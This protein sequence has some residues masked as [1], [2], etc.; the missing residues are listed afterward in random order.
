MLTGVYYPE[1]DK[2]NLPVIVLEKME[3]SLTSLMKKHKHFLWEKKLSILNDVCYG[4]QYLHGRNPPIIHRDLTPNNILLCDHHRAKISDLGVAKAMYATDAKT[5]TQNPGTNVFMP[6]ESLS[7]KPVYG[8]SLDIF[9]FGGVILFTCTQKWPELSGFIE[10]DCNTG[11]RK[12]LTEIQRRQ[13]YLDEMIGAFKDLK[14]LALSCLDDN[15]K[16]RPLVAKVL[17]EVK[18]VKD[19]YNEK[20]Y[21]TVLATGEHST[22]QLQH[23]ELEQQ[24]VL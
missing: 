14:S 22:T 19:M 12:V 4:L 23:Q 16:N 8:L 15:P 3:F 1:K 5:L 24:K 18:K 2:F 7:S 20:N 6:P 11:E 17:M 21:I 9:S 13:Q 10:F